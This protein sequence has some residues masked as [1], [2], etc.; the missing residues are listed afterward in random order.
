MKSLPWTFKVAVEVP[1]GHRLALEWNEYARDLLNDIENKKEIP[2]ITK[3]IKDI[4][5]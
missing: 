1:R 5:L 4:V 3:E 2:I